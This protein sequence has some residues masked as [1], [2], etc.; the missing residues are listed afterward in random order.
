[1]YVDGVVIPVAKKDMQAYKNYCFHIQ[2]AFMEN[3]ASRFVECWADDV[4]TGEKTSFPM[5]VDLQ[6]G[7][8]VV[9]SWIEWTDKDTRDKGWEA[10]MADPRIKDLGDAMPFD[11]SRMIFG[12]FQGIVEASWE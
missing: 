3:G 8:A 9:F 7:E 4:P 10:A 2:G 12:G 5:A 1:M 11:R 6:P